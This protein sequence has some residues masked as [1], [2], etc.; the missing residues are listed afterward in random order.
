MAEKRQIRSPL[1]VFLGGEYEVV[2]EFEVESKSNSE[3]V[4]AD[5]E[6][7]EKGGGDKEDDEEEEQ[8]E[9][10]EDEEDEEDEDGEDGEE[11]NK[12]YDGDIVED[13]VNKRVI[14][15]AV[16]LYL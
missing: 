1:T 11:G 6:K 14:T 2:E 16:V 4:S 7:D 12:E 3:A 9:K 15:L 13:N 5:I 8:E 10:K